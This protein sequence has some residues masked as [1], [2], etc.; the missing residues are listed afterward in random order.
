MGGLRTSLLLLTCSC[1]DRYILGYVDITNPCAPGLRV[2][3]VNEA[4]ETKG[5]SQ[6]YTTRTTYYMYVGSVYICM[7]RLGFYS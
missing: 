2:S 3:S 7:N 1:S 6:F 5:Y 4:I